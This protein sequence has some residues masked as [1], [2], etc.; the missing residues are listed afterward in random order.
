MEG[1]VVLHTALSRQTLNWS[2]GSGA[3]ILQ[4]QRWNIK[5][6]GWPR[7]RETEETTEHVMRWGV[8]RACGQS[9]Q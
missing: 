1:F 4:G 8:F 2:L 5:V 3:T 6:T 7:R 9:L